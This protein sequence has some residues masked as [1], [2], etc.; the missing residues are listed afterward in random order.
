MVCLAGAI[1][2]AG[3]WLGNS[4]VGERQARLAPGT[5]KQQTSTEH[6]ACVP[7]EQQDPLSLLGTPLLLSTRTRRPVFC[8]SW[9]CVP[10]PPLHPPP[11]P[12][13][14]HPPVPCALSP[15]AGT[16]P[17]PPF[18][19]H[20][21]PPRPLLHLRFPSPRFVS[22]PFPCVFHRVFH[23]T[24]ETLFSRVR[25]FGNLLRS[26]KAFRSFGCDFVQNQSLQSVS[27]SRR[28]L[29][30]LSF[31]YRIL[32]SSA[33]LACQCDTCMCYPALTFSMIPR[34]P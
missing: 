31:L 20:P 5:G 6:R 14:F 4:N 34:T 7:P 25:S 30:V 28:L 16:A 19:L 32:L 11:A 33:R 26:L 24:R 1:C 29:S 13:S 12:P 23:P 10:G 15:C 3:R 22:T 21:L 17:P 8:A 9:Q 27:R 2:S 18:P